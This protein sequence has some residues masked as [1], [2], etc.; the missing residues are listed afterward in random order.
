[1]EPSGTNFDMSNILTLQ[2]QPEDYSEPQE[3]GQTLMCE[4]PV[5]QIGGQFVQLRV[6]E[7]PQQVEGK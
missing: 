1:M 5:S 2:Y 4:F 7:Q 3:F 6:L